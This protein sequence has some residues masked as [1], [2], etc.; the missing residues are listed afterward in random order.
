M[1][2]KKEIE[3]SVDSIIK[4]LY[5]QLEY[6]SG[7]AKLAKLRNSMGRTDLVEVYPFLYGM[8]SKELRKYIERN[9]QSKLSD[10]EK[11]II[12]SLQL[13]ALLQQG[14]EDCVHEKTEHLNFGSSLSELRKD[15]KDKEDGTNKVRNKKDQENNN[16]VA[17]DRRFNAMILADTPEEFQVHLRHILQLYK[18]KIKNGTIDFVKLATDI[19]R[20]IKWEHGKVEIRLEWSR[21]YYKV[22]YKEE[23]K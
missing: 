20:F 4:Q 14:R 18:S 15:N 2:A 7:K 22:N 10:E 23:E 3:T 19:Y 9:S 5:A 8:I 17:I 6:S 12:W 11:A 13:Y 16:S 21:E 1:D